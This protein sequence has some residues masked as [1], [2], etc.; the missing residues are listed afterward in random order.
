MVFSEICDIIG[1]FNKLERGVREVF[2]LE[3]DETRYNMH[4]A[5]KVQL[6]LLVDCATR[7]HARQLDPISCAGRILFC[8]HS[9]GESWKTKA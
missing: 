5:C 3:L 1:Y 9:I 7:L 6:N 2:L 4:D 8:L